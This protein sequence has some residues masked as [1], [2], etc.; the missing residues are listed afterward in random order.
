[1]EC[2]ASHLPV[3]EQSSSENNGVFIAPVGGVAPLES[4]WVP[5]VF[6]SHKTN[7]PVRERLPRGKTKLCLRREEMGM[8]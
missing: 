7:Q 4:H 8:Q 5:V 3:I 1:M 2:Y 6:V